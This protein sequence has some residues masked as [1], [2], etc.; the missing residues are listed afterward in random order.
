MSSF[1]SLEEAIKEL[2]LD[3][4]RKWHVWENTVIFDYWYTH[5]C[6]GCDGCGCHECGY[7]GK[8]RSLVPVP[9]LDKNNNIVTIKEKK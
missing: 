3:R 8:R 9:A 6:S 7:K 1:N 4:R 2:Q 5:P